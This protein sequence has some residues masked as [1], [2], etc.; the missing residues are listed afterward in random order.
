MKKYWNIVDDVVRNSDIIIEVLDARFIEET[1]NRELE[2]KIRK[3]KKKLIYAINKSDLLKNV[4]IDDIRLNLKDYVFVSARE[5]FGTTRLRALIR[6]LIVKKPVN[7]G[8]VGYPNTGKS[9]L[10]NA[11]RQRSV[12]RTSPVPGFTKG[13][14]KIKIGEGVYL[15]DTPGVIHY[16]LENEV[17]QALINT[18]DISKIKDPEGVAIK[19]IELLCMNNNKII[20]K[21]YSVKAKNSPES[22]L[23]DIA[24]KF[25]WL[26]KGGEP[27]IDLASRR[28]I[29][30]WQ[31]GKISL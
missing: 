7:I 19:I 6:S 24:R 17:E 25:N 3:Q 26:V 15:I 29:Q 23:N 12:A 30:D 14:Q 11:L 27:N 16:K 20:E 1:R 9:S 21:V 2:E 28:I 10:I 4:K 13:I 8:V 22:I 31:R 18:K 5:N